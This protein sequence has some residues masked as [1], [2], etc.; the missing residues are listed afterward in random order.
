M[1]T[2]PEKAPLETPAEQGSQLM[3][4]K[5]EQPPQQKK[6]LWAKRAVSIP[7]ACLATVLTIVVVGA[8]SYYAWAYGSTSS[9]VLA[10][11]IIWQTPANVD[12]YQRFPARTIATA[13]PTFSFPRAPAGN[14]YTAA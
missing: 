2:I 14:P 4:Q 13:S 11:Q 3:N 5:P 10:R 9:S 7:L 8:G 6:R 12:D 1:S